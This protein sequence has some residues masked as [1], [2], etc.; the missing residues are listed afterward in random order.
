[1]KRNSIAEPSPA[2]QTVLPVLRELSAELDAGIRALARED[3]NEFEKHVAAQ[4]KI[5]DLLLA[6]KLFTDP[7]GAR[8]RSPSAMPA[9]QAARAAQETAKTL[10]HQKRVFAALIARARRYGEILLAAHRSHRGYT[11]S[12]PLPL[13]G[14]TW[15]R[16]V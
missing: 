11:A 15:S 6:T 16:E 9:E 5:C 4:E 14:Q 3:L 1:M 2:W 8:F 12:G 7:A 13:E 10:D